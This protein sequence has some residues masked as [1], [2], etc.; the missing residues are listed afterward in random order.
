[1][2]QMLR[3]IYIAGLHSNISPFELK[4]TDFRIRVAQRRPVQGNSGCVQCSKL[5]SKIGNLLTGYIDSVAGDPFYQPKGKYVVFR[6]M[7]MPIKAQIES[8]GII[9]LETVTLSWGSCMAIGIFDRTL[10]L[11]M[12]D[13]PW[14]RLE[15]ADNTERLLR[16]S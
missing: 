7:T 15:K 4:T 2:R 14:T 11:L 9:L 12:R 16:S 13:F 1:V 6:W 3:A 10:L 5:G 8:M